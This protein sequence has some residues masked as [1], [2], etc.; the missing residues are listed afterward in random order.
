MLDHEEIWSLNE[1]SL[2]NLYSNINSLRKSRLLCDVILKVEHKEFHAH[3][4]VLASNSD[5][6]LA[7]FTNKMREKDS[8]II[9]LQGLNAKTMETLLNC[10]YNEPIVFNNEN[11]Q[12]ILSAASLLQLTDIQISCSEFLKNQLDPTNCIGIK[13]FAETHGCTKLCKAALDYLNEN[14]HSIIAFDE[15]LNLK[16]NDLEDIIKQDDIDVQSEEIIYNAVFNWIKYD[17]NERAKYLPKLINH[18]RLPLL[19][20]KFLTDVCD[21]EQLIKNSFECRDLL[22]EA[23]KYHLRPDLRFEMSGI[24]FKNRNG[25]FFEYLFNLKLILIL[26]YSFQRKI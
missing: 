8:S 2:K 6:F 7:M 16:Y 9:E 5:Y 20:P 22:D 3:R 4:I 19:S 1:K 25:I 26:F 13:H 24:R 11:V 21:K 18:V 10:I 23:K 14:F 15:F 17:L 12:E